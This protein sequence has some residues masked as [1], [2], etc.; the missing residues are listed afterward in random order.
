MLMNKG[1]VVYAEAQ[2][3]TREYYNVEDGRTNLKYV[4]LV[5]EHSASATE[6][7]ATGVKA[8]KEGSIVGTTTYGK[9][10]I[11]TAFELQD[12]SVVKMTITQYYSPSGEPI[13]KVG[14]VPD[15][16]VELP[17]A[18]ENGE[19]EDAQLLKAIE[20]LR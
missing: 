12:G 19:V 8:N 13:H 7:L 15:Y 17:E 16:V 3:G 10:I 18:D 20:L 2:D 11:Q 9:G 1:T 4:L 14:V 6:I 5:N